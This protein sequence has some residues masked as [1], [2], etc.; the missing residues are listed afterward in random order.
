ML[1]GTRKGIGNTSDGVW[2]SR[3]REV[4][5]CETDAKWVPGGW[6]SVRDIH[7]FCYAYT[8]ANWL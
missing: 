4:T 1:V 7:L 2:R 5:V 3:E 6:A 8:G